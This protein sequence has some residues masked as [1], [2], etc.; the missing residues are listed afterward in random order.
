MRLKC[1]LPL[2]ERL[3]EMVYDTT[4]RKELQETTNIPGA[5]SAPPGDAVRAMTSS[6]APAGRSLAGREQTSPGPLP[7]TDSVSGQERDGRAFQPPF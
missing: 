1:H 3:R 2:Q 7:A 6:D 4:I 5:C